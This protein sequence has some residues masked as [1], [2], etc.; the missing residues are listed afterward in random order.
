MST[1]IHQTTIENSDTKT[2][3]IVSYVL[4]TLGLF[5][6]IPMLFGGIWAMVKRSDALGTIY[7]SHFTNAIRTFWWTLFWTIVGF[8]LIVVGVGYLIL[9]G[10]WLWA[11]YRL[12][13]G[14]AKITSDVA[15]PL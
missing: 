3:A 1:T 7:H 13:N 5:T 4:L 6:G 10:A 2:H 9:C 11:L 12:V 14:F 15:Y 8:M